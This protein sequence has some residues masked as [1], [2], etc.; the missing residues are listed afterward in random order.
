MFLTQKVAKS[1][2]TRSVKK[3]SRNKTATKLFRSQNTTPK[4]I[5]IKRINAFLTQLDNNEVLMKNAS[6]REYSELSN[7]KKVMEND[8][9]KYEPV[10]VD[11][12]MN[13]ISEMVRKQK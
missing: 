5:A 13:C 10:I 4:N 12:D 1:E 3:H 8:F 6:K 2:T 7:M 9:L 11:D